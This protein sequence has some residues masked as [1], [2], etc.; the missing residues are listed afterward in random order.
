MRYD[1]LI[2]ALLFAIS[3][4]MLITFIFAL[5]RREFLLGFVLL[6]LLALASG[7]YSLCYG[8][9]I[10]SDSETSMLLFAHCEFIAVPF[11]PL[12]WFFISI[13]QRTKVRMLP[14]KRYW[15][16][17]IIPVLSVIASILFPWKAGQDTTLLQRAFIA[18]YLYETDTAIG[19]GFSTLIFQKGAMF[20][21]LS[22]Y[23]AA[24][25]IA[26]AV[27]YYDLFHKAESAHRHDILTLMV[28]SLAVFCIL[29]FSL[30]FEQTTAI[31]SAASPFIAGIITI[32]VMICLYKYEFFDLIPFAYRH[33]FQSVSVPI[34][35]LDKSLE[36]ISANN[37]ARRFYGKYFDFRE[38]L[39]LQDFDRI[40]PEFYSDLMKIGEH[41]T[42]IGTDGEKKY[43]MAK[44][45]KLLGAKNRTLGYLLQ[46]IDITDHKIEL[47]RMESVATYDD[48]TKIFNR[49]VFYIKAA[50]AFDEAILDKEQFSFIMF[51]LDNF[52]EI[53]D[54]YGHQAGDYVLEKMAAL[55]ETA[56]DTTDIF[57]RYGGEEFIIFCQKRDPEDAAEL[58]EKMRVMLDDHIFEFN[59]RKIRTSA[60]FGVSGSNGTV[61]KSFEKYIK[62]SDDGLY[63]SKSK[64]KNKVEIVL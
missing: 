31:S 41:E 44:L 25:F 24:L 12:L 13:Q 32:F 43:Y 4:F 55:F 59:N 14:M 61:R 63:V 21:I 50:E 35:I 18:S 26:S 52:K 27:N 64:G 6:G 34:F 58:A 54:V 29:I 17:L 10:L 37:I 23:S 2:A 15:P 46:Y 19:S 48:L 9:F 45:E 16:F 56:L 60:S 47:A 40:D 53:N 38:L 33:L 39:F 51:D 20:F 3:A 11:I 1:F 28:M 49:R 36:L 42:S 8:G 22:A 5:T 57:A 7:I 62:D 30:S